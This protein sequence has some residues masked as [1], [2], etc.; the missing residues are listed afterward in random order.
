MRYVFGPFAASNV[1][2]NGNSLCAGQVSPSAVLGFVGAL[3]RRLGHP[4]WNFAVLPVFH[5][6]S[7][8]EG[9]L[10][11]APKVAGGVQKSD[12]LAESLIGEVVC[13]LII[14]TEHLLDDRKVGQVLPKLKFAG[15][16]IRTLDQS[17]LHDK[18][19]RLV[20]DTLGDAE[21]RIRRGYAM[22]PPTDR[23]EAK[24][25]SFGEI[26]SLRKVDLF[27]RTKRGVGGGYFIPVPA[28]YRLLENAKSATPRSGSRDPETPHVF[29]SPAV[30]I[31]EVVSVRSPRI[32]TASYDDLSRF[33]WR[34]SCD[35]IHRVTMFSRIHLTATQ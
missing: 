4:T 5:S 6:V 21:P 20:G 13:S 31:A 1:N 19:S 27:L 16:T 8:S 11:P 7:L 10:R 18:F 14:E 15:G 29:S 35:D 25:V 24:V 32:D 3:L 28:G 33:M 26:E 9:R 23:E 17:P 12:D 22:V 2:L 30:G 34:W